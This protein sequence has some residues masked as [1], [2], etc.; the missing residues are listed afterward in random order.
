[1]FG[2]RYPV[3]QGGLGYWSD[4][5]LAAAVCNAG[6]LGVITSFPFEDKK[7][8]R[9]EIQKAK[10][11]T[12]K[13]FGVN[14]NLFPASRPAAN[15]E[16]VEI[17]IEEGVAF[18]E[19][20]G[21]SPEAYLEKLHQAGVKVIHKVPGTQYARHAEK[22]GVDAVTVVGFEGG[23][24]PG[25]GEV[26]TLVLVPA[27]KKQVKIPIIAA[28][29]IASGAGLLAALALGAEGVTVGTR[30]L[31]TKESPLHHAVKERLLKAK[32]T[33]T[34]IID[35]SI[36]SARRVLRNPA[37]ERVLGMQ[38]IGA[39]LDEQLA[40]MGGQASRVF[41]DKGDLEHGVISCGQSIGLIDDAPTVKEV[42]ER[43][44]AE[45]FDAWDSLGKQTAD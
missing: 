33:E 35:R 29:G 17:V 14:I 8:L 23:G 34:M 37:A 20:S 22:I 4:A 21:R 9:K 7:E 10:K 18:V 1:M 26:T 40:V 41:L 38:Q 31:T 16:V 44:A 15:E 3:I 12:E 25:M 27:T 32:E 30:F 2:C 28:G 42:M 5:E 19:T 43:I 45:A 11:L 24:H 13:P 6:G 39:S 36:K